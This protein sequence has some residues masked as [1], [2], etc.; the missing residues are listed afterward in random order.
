MPYKHRALFVYLFGIIILL[1]GTISTAAQ[2][3][4]TRVSVS[5]HGTQSNNDSSERPVISADGR[6]VAFSSNATNLVANDGNN[7]GN[8]DSTRSSISANGQYVAFRSFATDLVAGDTNGKYDTFVRGP[9]VDFP[10]PM[11]LPAITNAKK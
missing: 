10:W 11:Y 4:T 7:G 8:D 9:M 2:P 6:Y 3:V 1:F 5:S